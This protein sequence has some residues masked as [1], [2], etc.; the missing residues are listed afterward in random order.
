MEVSRELLGGPL[1]EEMDLGQLG[2]GPT[3]GCHL[4]GR[5]MVGRGFHPGVRM[6]DSCLGREGEVDS[7][8]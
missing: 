7:L 4:E 2:L 6:V 3:V 1:K 8:E 5:L